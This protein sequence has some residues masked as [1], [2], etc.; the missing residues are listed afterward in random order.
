MINCKNHL[1]V[2]LHESKL[3]YSMNWMV[4]YQMNGVAHSGHDLNK[5]YLFPSFDDQSIERHSF[6]GLAV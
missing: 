2:C 5:L 3:L 1:S 4:I 6:S